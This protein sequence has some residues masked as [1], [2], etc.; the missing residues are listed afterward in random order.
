M[1]K[2]VAVRPR[3]LFNVNQIIQS[4]Y[5]KKNVEKKKN[6]VQCLSVRHET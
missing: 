6:T 2:D 3:E 1:Y 5:A 4:R